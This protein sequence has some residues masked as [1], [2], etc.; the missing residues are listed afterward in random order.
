MHDQS[1][2]A[3]THAAKGLPR[4][5]PIPGV[6]HV[7]VVS[8]AKGGVGKSTTAGEAACNY[9]ANFTKHSKSG[10]WHDCSETSLFYQSRFL[11][12]AQADS[13][14]CWQGLQVGLLDADVFGPSIPKMMNLKGLPAVSANKLMLPHQNFGIKWS[15]IDRIFVVVAAAVDAAPPAS[16]N[17][18]TTITTTTTTTTTDIFAAADG[19]GCSS[20]ID[21]SH[22]D[23]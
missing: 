20:C 12:N 18:R 1:K 4:K 11:N 7:V 9:H 15:V 10:P 14:N 3:A 22:S 2:Q 8:S 23:S 16:A 19:G 13:L 21:S 6:K 17:N 5:W